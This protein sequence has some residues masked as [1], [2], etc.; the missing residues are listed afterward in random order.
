MNTKA[1]VIIAILSFA[2]LT[3]VVYAFVQQTI[4]KEVQ[5]EA[6]EQKMASE[7]ARAEAERQRIEAEMQRVVAEDTM[8]KL[9]TALQEL[10]LLKKRCK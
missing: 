7:V 8:G 3:S 2:M 1:I 4:A 9:Q 6:L 10:E 5:R